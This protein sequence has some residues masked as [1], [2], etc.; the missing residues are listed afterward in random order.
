MKTIGLIGGMSWESSIEY[1]RLVNQTARERLGGLHNAK[2]VMVTVDFAEIERMQHDGR[3]DDAGA[4][5]N[6]AA[7]Q[8]EAGGADFVVLCTNT[9][10]KV[11]DQMMRGVSIPLLHIADATARRI[12][13][14]GI[15]RIALLGTDYTMSQDFYKGRLRDAFGLDVLIPNDADRA[16]VHRV[17]YD[18]LCLGRVEA[19]SKRAY[20]DVIQRLV[21]HGAQ[22]VIAGCT[23]ITLLVKQADL[24]VP[25][26]D[27]TAI[28][29]EEAVASALAPD[30]GRQTADGRS[31]TV[32]GKRFRSVANTP[33]GQVSG[34]TVFAYRQNGGVVWATYGGG[35]IQSGTLTGVVH[36]DGALDFRYAHVDTGGVIRTGECVSTPETLAD[37]RMRLNEKWRWTNGDRSSGESTIEEIE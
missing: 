20:L 23:E 11:A 16:V 1:Y 8:L 28:H 19:T 31:W 25:Y 2:S 21:D 30:R 32:D 3:W 27:T 17:I 14:A 10:H 12:V 6:A 35:A 15:S 13:A 7:R 33:N 22:G 9:M 5:L 18:E 26:F 34:D 4:V 37:G 24:A 29:A 36:D